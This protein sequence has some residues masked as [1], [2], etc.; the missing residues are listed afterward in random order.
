MTNRRQLILLLLLFLPLGIY[1]ADEPTQEES[2]KTPYPEKTGQEQT[3][4]K[5][6]DQ[7][8]TE[9]SGSLTSDNLKTRDL[10]EAFR[11]FRP[12]EEISADNAVPF[13]VDI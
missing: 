5:Q 6:T 7:G 3:R 12:S 9:Q 10:G 8:E 13:P 1:P 4:Q 11:N 2:E